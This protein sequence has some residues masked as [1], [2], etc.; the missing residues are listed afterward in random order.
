MA[1]SLGLNLPSISLGRAL[2]IGC[3]LVTAALLAIAAA[4]Q[5]DSVEASADLESSVPV[6]FGDWEERPSPFV[7]VSLATGVE[8]NMNQPYDQTV[9]RTYENSEGQVVYLAL[10]WG[11]QQRQEV[12]VHRPDLCY[13]AQGFKVAELETHRFSD[14]RTPAGEQVVGKHM[15][16]LTSGGGE[17]VSYWIRIGTLYSEDAFETRLRI[18]RDGLAGRIPDGI[19]VRASMRL[20]RPEDANEAWP[21]LDKFLHQL[22]DATQVPVRTMLVR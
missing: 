19:L 21:L 13:V 7:Q 2:S 10:A 18:L 3:A 1:I 8:A 14:I 11:A 9:M 15:L 16:A 12:K 20:R 5:P 6:R 22:V 4:P 17:A